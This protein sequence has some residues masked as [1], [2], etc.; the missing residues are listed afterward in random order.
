MAFS[1][2]LGG[3]IEGGGAL[4]GG[5]FGGP[6]GMT[7]GL[8]AGNRLGGLAS[9]YFKKPSAEDLELTQLR[10]RLATPYQDQPINYDALA[11]AEQRRYQQ[12]IMPG[13]REQYMGAGGG[14]SAL[15]NALA[16]GGSDLAARLAELK[17]GFQERQQ[18]AGRDVYGMNQQGMMGL[19]NL[20]QGRL[21]QQQAAS[22][23]QQNRFAQYASAYPKNIF[24]QR[25][26]QLDRA[27]GKQ[28]L[29]SNW[30]R[31]ILMGLG[32]NRAARSDSY[33]QLG[34]FSNIAQEQAFDTAQRQYMTPGQQSVQAIL[35]VL[36]EGGK[37]GS[38]VGSAA[39]LSR[40]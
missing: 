34:Q 26:L 29:E 28:N 20:L 33:N 17:T 39:L 5:Y 1:D 2:I 22:E 3:L 23:A 15:A 4:A 6:V 19:A 24:E 27:A 18:Q 11:Q 12:E 30:L 25:K 9:S 10:K 36:Q 40:K 37:I 31:D 35:K 38:E 8:A 14:S 13:I 21:Q 32:E 16:R 7:A